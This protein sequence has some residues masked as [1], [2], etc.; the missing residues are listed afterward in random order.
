MEFNGKVLLKTLS[1]DYAKFLERAGQGYVPSENTQNL[2]TSIY[3]N[4]D[5][6]SVIRQIYCIEVLLGC[7][8]PDLFM[9]PLPV[10]ILFYF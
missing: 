9:S 10:K 4:S 8:N 3:Y 7:T 2:I 5:Q 6:L 1:G